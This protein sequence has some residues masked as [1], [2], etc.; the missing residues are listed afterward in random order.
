MRWSDEYRPVYELPVGSY[1]K[2][3]R[4]SEQ[5]YQIRAWGRGGRRVGFWQGEQLCF[6]Y[7]SD[8]RVLS[9]C[10]GEGRTE[11]ISN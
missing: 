4:G 6:T 3:S 11:A 5:V 9:A 1:V 7:P 8:V 10:E 2:L